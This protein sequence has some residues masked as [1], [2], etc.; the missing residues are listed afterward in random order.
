MHAAAGANGS[1]N[2]SGEVGVLS[3][4]NKTFTITPNSGY[5]TAAVLV[6]GVN[7]GAVAAYTF[8]NITAN[9]TISASF[10]PITP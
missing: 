5:K 7:K 2:P 9:H 1:I 4:T 6:D 10:S 8:N 3:G